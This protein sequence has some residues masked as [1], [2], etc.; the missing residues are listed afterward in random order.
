MYDGVIFDLD[1][2]V[3]IG[4]ELISGA[5]NVLEDLQSAGLQVGFATNNTTK[6]PAM[7]VEKLGRLGI[8]VQEEQVTNPIRPLVDWLQ[9][10]V[11]GSGVFALCEDPMRE[12]LLTADIRLVEEPEEVDVVVASFD[13]TLDYPK[14]RTAFQALWGNPECR[15]VATH[16]DPYCPLPAGSGEP[17][18][19]ALVGALE[20]AANVRCEMVFGKPSDNLFRSACKTLGLRPENCLMVGDRLNTDIAMAE[21]VGA[22]SVL[23]L[24]G[25]SRR[26]DIAAHPDGLAPSF[27]LPS[28]VGIPAAIG[29]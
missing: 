27:V 28:L 19:G 20:A 14:L 29:L 3:Y 2:T 21:G 5:K 22:D 6:T 9:G 10:E 11:K 12:V 8:S 26:A 13:R 23:V 18:A 1:G 25:D 15:L 24:T 17:D 7:Y 4:D 16:L